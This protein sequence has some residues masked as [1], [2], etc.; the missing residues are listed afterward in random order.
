MKA[1]MSSG[2]SLRSARSIWT[3][4]RRLASSISGRSGSMPRMLSDAL[5]RA[6]SLH[7]KARGIRASLEIDQESD[8]VEISL[9]S[10]AE[11]ARQHRLCSSPRM[12]AVPGRHLAIDDGRSDRLLGGPVRRLELGMVEVS[13]D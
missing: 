6:Q 8:N 11:H 12:A 9:A 10:G 4:L 1:P 7:R 13:K 5:I 2:S 3:S